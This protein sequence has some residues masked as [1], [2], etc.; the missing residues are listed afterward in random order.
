M[1]PKGTIYHIYTAEKSGLHGEVSL[2]APVKTKLIYS[3]ARG[4][5]A[6]LIGFI[7]ISFIFTFGPLIQD[8]VNY[9]LGTNKIEYQPSQVDLVNAQNTTVIQNEARSFGVDSY[10]SVVIPKIG[11]KAN[12]IANVDPTNEKEYDAALAEGV[13]HA[14]GTYFP[15][16]GQSIYLFAHSTNGP[17]N[18]ARYNAV[19]YLLDKMTKGDQI[20]VYFA[21]KRYVYEV[22]ATKI[23]GPNDTSALS[24]QSSSEQ[25]ILQTCYPPG[26]SWNRLLVFAKPVN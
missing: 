2:Q 18:V 13:A 25:L 7:I 12:I 4:I 1:Y 11:A 24:A 17:W 16:Q 15:G 10:F 9:N 5:G 14:K 3:L 26:T 8:E 20:I 21:D 6:G 19:F 23:V 22:T